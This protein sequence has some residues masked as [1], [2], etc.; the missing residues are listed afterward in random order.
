MPEV[1]SIRIGYPQAG[2]LPY[3]DIEILK[4]D[5]MDI[6]HILRVFQKRRH[7]KI[8]QDE[9]NAE[10]DQFIGNEF[11]SAVAVERLWV[12]ITRDEEEKSH[13]KGGIESKEKPQRSDAFSGIGIKPAASRRSISLPDV[14]H[15]DQHN[16][17]HLEVVEIVKPILTRHL[18]RPSLYF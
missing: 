17:E 16:Q 3:P 14:V 12:E 8:G 15:D 5:R 7:E 1:E 2:R 11:T 4:A 18:P 13:E 6:M 9:R 10:A